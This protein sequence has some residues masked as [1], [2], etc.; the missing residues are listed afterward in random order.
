MAMLER[1]NRSDKYQYM[2][3]EVLCGDVIWNNFANQDTIDYALNPYRYDE[4]L[5]NLQDQLKEQ[6]WKM[7]SEVCTD[8]QW[9]CLT[10]YCNGM[11]Q[12][13][14]AKELGVNQSSITKCLNGNVDYGNDKKVYGGVT[15]KLKKAAENNKAIQSILAQIS[16]L[17]VEKL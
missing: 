8:I 11:T 15:K 16:D 10:M 1:K 2:I 14:I 17:T 4:K 3:C 12:C 13:E 9:K 7:A 6:V 5:L